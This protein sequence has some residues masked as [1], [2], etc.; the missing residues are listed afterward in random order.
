MAGHAESIGFRG[1]ISLYLPIENWWRNSF[2][3]W[4]FARA[5][6]DRD[7]DIEAEMAKYCRLYYGRHAKAMN[8]IFQMIFS[9]L[10]N[11]NLHSCHNALGGKNGSPINPEGL[12]RT[13]KAAEI[14]LKKLADIR[15]QATDSAIIDRFDRID[16]YI[17]YFRLY[18]Q[19]YSTQSKSQLKKLIEFS[20]QNSK[21]Q[22][23]VLM[24]PEYI[25]WRCGDYYT[26]D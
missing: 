7:L 12:A 13:E 25:Q 10:Q 1:V 26:K 8:E 2:N 4:F 22:D 11:E 6:W 24:Y 17:R 20:R 15:T 3:T 9:E 16:I 23:G 21:F 19:V 5:C 14:I 18:Y